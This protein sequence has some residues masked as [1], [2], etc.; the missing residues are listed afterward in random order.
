MMW[1]NAA[2]AADVVGLL[3]RDVRCG[4]VCKD[5]CGCV[6]MCLRVCVC[7]CVEPK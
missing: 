2:A 6:C 3:A 4:C 5:M 1:S 7:T